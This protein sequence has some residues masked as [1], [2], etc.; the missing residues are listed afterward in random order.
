[1]SFSNLDLAQKKFLAKYLK[2]GRELAQ[3]A[4]QNAKEAAAAN[5]A[6]EEQRAFRKELEV[7]VAEFKQLKTMSFPDKGDIEKQVAGMIRTAAELSKAREHR[8]AENTLRDAR[9]RM[10]A[11]RIGVDAAAAKDIRPAD[12]E[13]M[14]A[15]PD[16]IRQLDS[17]IDNLTDDVPPRVMK[18]LLRARFGLGERILQSTAAR[19]NSLVDK[20]KH[21]AMLDT[22][23][24]K[25]KKY[26][27]EI[28]AEI[29]AEDA[30]NN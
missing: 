13:V 22:K 10:T 3:K 28:M 18:D 19:E 15:T 14:L 6:L 11:A 29:E 23:S 21:G 9:A 4:V 12:I 20:A 1:M 25:L 8:R 2:S 27:A 30:A 24:P 5:E 17:M 16:G 26:W 7:V